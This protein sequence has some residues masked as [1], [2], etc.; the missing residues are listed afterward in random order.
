MRK[1]SKLVYSVQIIYS[2]IRSSTYF[3]LELFKGFVIYQWLDVLKRQIVYQR[4]EDRFEE[5]WKYIQQDNINIPRLFSIGYSLLY[6]FV[7]FLWISCIVL[8]FHFYD[9]FILRVI[10]VT[11]GILLV[12]LQ[13]YAIHLILLFDIEQQNNL[14]KTLAIGIDL[15]IREWN[16]LFYI[17]L[18]NILFL[19]L[20]FLQPIVFI[21][22]CPGLYGYITNKLNNNTKKKVVERYDLR[23]S[24]W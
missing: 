16:I 7:L 13:T 5:K 15:L 8:L 12:L 20:L 21:F 11:L 10:V 18:L 2:L 1:K 24:V 3:W 17:I 9:H 14:Y 22:I 19:L 6:S 23:Q 4:S